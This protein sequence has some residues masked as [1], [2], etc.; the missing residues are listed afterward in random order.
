MDAQLSI[1]EDRVVVFIGL[2][3]L[4]I[5]NFMDKFPM[6]DLGHRCTDCKWQRGGNA[7]N[8]ATVFALLG[9]TTRFFGTLTD[10]DEIAFL[11]KDLRKYNICFDKCP[12]IANSTCPLSVVI[13]SKSSG[14]RTV[15]HTNTNLRELTLEDF[16]T[17]LD[18]G[19]DG[20]GWLH[21]EGRDNAFNIYEMIKYVIGFNE[22]YLRGSD[23]SKA[24]KGIKISLE[25]EKI[26]FS[27]GMDQYNLWQLPDV[28]FIS[29]DFAKNQGYQNM[30]EAAQ[31]YFQKAKKGALVVCAW[32]E[33]GAAAMSD[34]EGLVT[35]PAFPPSEIVDTC[36]AGDTFNASVIRALSSGRTLQEAIIFGCK[37]AGAKCGLRGYDG[38]EKFQ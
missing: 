18:L 4:D 31:G 22:K 23:L 35:S 26:R 25:V 37:I 15:L 2:V 20:M 7:S 3:C 32:G 29:K 11:I 14:S 34:D 24:K 12:K 36:G 6:E 21:F 8:S 13:L 28:L 30:K 16:K 9:G 19:S 5:V 33:F 10:S 1:E 27:S 17:H 38:V